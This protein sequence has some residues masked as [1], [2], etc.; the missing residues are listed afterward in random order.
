MSTLRPAGPIAGAPPDAQA[1]LRVLARELESVFLNQ[2][3]QA[4][5]ATVQEG[6]PGGQDPAR[7]AYE[8]MLDQRLAEMAAGRVGRGL[9]EAL[10]RQLARRL[11]AAGG[12]TP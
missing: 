10:Y 7:E 1:E 5:R 12:T 3:L 2:L 4:M 9:G 8:S 11:D 6:G